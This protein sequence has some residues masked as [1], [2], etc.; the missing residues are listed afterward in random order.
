MDRSILVV[1]E[2]LILPKLIGIVNLIKFV[3]TENSS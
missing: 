1:L 3:I 2:K